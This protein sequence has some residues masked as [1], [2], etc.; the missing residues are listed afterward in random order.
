MPRKSKID[1]CHLLKILIENKNS[2]IDEKTQEI[3][4]PSHPCWIDI[5]K[6]F[7]YAISVKYIYAIVKLDRY[8]VLNK[9]GLKT[10]HN[11]IEPELSDNFNTEQ[12]DDIDSNK[13]CETTEEDESI[14]S[15]NITLSKEEWQ[16]IYD[17]S[18]SVRSYHRSDNKNT[19]R[20]YETLTPYIWTPIINEH[21]FEQTRLSCA[22]TYKYAKIYLNGQVF[23]D[24][25]G[26]CSIC[27]SNFK[28]IVIDKPES[29]SRVI[30][31]CSYN[32]QFNSCK[33]GKKR[34]IIGKKRDYFL[35]KLIKENQSAAYVQ[36]VEAK[37]IMH[38]GEAEP[39]HIPS[40]NALRVMKYKAN[41]INRIHEDPITALSLLKASLPYNDIIRDIGYDRFFVHYWSSTEI[42]SYRLYA[43]NNKLPT[44]SIDATGGLVQKPI[45]IS[46][47]QTSNIFLYQI[48]VRDTKNKCQF[49]VGHMLSER[50]DN[51]SIAY[52][53]AEWL[54]ND[55]SPPKVIVTDQ[56]LALMMAAVKTFTQYANLNKYISICS[57][58]IQKEINIEVPNCMIRN[59]FNHVMH[60]LSS[61]IEYKS[62]SRRVKNFYLR[63]IGLIIV[64]T[65]FEDIKILLKLIFTVSLNETE[66]VDNNG[67]L[68]ECEMA[69]TCLKQRIATHTTDVE[70]IIEEI[71]NKEDD[72]D[73]M[74]TN[75]HEKIT[76]TTI[77]QQILDIYESC[78]TNSNQQSNCGDHDNLQFSP[79]IAKKLLDFCKLLPCWSA[80]M[81]PI[82]NFG[83]PT[84]SSA[85]SESLFNDLKSNVLR[86]KTLPLRIDEFITIHINSIIGSINLIGAKM[87]PVKK[88]I[89]DVKINTN[90]LSTSTIFEETES[91][92]EDEKS[93]GSQTE[94]EF[95]NWRGLGLDK[96]EQNNKKSNYL[97]KDPNILYY[98]ENSKT[99]SPIIGLLKNGNSSHLKSITIEKK[100]YLFTNTCAFDSVTQVMM[101]AFADSIVYADFIS[102]NKMY[103]FFEMI[104]NMLRDGI[105]VQTYK[106]RGILCRN[107]MPNINPVIDVPGGLI[108]INCACTIQF[109]IE[110]LFTNFPSIKETTLC[111]ECTFELNRNRPI[112]T[113]NLPTETLEF[114]LD[115]IDAIISNPSSTINNICRYC[116]KGQLMRNFE[117]GENIFIEPVKNT[118]NIKPD[119]TNFNLS[120]VLNDIPK[121]INIQ[122]KTFNIK[123]IIEFIPPATKNINSIGHYIAYT[124]RHHTDNWEKHDDLGNS[125]R[126][127]R[128]N[129][130]ANHCQILIYTV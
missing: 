96:Y 58:L 35:D 65:D 52:W 50:H 126:S 71:K 121:R 31:N 21:F 55:I 5:Q 38:Y 70:D 92:H 77:F 53:L 95:E 61:W 39:S 88:E 2:I 82:F 81:V 120:V 25:I 94:T 23:L 106:K 80:V 12:Y 45:L 76:S 124:Y 62:V 125:I 41:K 9:L 68:T 32:G 56:S 26:H 37:D 29:E 130:R 78:I 129:T 117:L 49:S 102:K 54:R 16:K 75:F 46:G 105:N 98:N 83:N 104:S 64:N 4:P 57:L 79:G 48:G 73:L 1:V 8:D 93:D 123:G 118:G 7:D 101:T 47:R 63:A 84:E 69:K 87:Y 103:V 42:N 33:S 128:Q 40:K 59:D 22:L 28:G 85:T 91:I 127:V 86:H 114:L 97:D 51:N 13:Y 67:Q 19:Y 60:L 111:S 74:Y 18:S 100:C 34:R 43:K 36:R 20:N 10:P 44:I 6:K 110:K 15:F 107:I 66:G 72:D 112:I 3:A 116:S 109:I 24:I 90:D 119:D 11:I 113:A 115:S 108:K 89:E 17:P 27:M 99:K 30:I 122:S 14:L